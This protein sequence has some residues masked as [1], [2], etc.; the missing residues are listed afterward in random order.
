MI[1]KFVSDVPKGNVYR[2]DIFVKKAYDSRLFYKIFNDDEEMAFEFYDSIYYYDESPY[3]LQQKALCLSLFC[4]SKEAF[5]AI[6]DA[7][8]FCPNNFSM[9]NSKAEIIY[10]ANK[11]FRTEKAEEQLH[12]ATA[13]L[14]ECRKNDKRQN[15]HAILYAKIVLHLNECYPNEINSSMITIALD[16]LETVN[17]E[18]DKQI[19]SLI[20]D[21]KEISMISNTDS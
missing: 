5:S 7:L 14:E 6:D 11:T 10:N 16:W 17:S 4:R 18:N 9:K 13:I 21:L 2:Y 20:S 3:T 1:S 19:Q 8:S 15:Y 12:K